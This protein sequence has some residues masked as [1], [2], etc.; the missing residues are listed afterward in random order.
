MKF[1][2]FEK[3]NQIFCETGRSIEN[4]VIEINFEATVYNFEAFMVIGTAQ[5]PLSSHTHSYV[6]FQN[7]T[8]SC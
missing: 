2:I 6:N 5:I 1:L 7:N 8:I 4:L 3:N